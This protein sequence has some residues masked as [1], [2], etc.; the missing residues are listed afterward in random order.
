[1]KKFI[2]CMIWYFGN[3]IIWAIDDLI[4]VINGTYIGVLEGDAILQ[5]TVIIIVLFLPM[6]FFKN[7]KERWNWCGA[8]NIRNVLNA[9]Q[10]KENAGQEDY[11]RI[12]IVD[13][14]EESG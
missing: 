8:R 13:I 5:G 12:V 4:K 3:L 7:D 10:P 11:V 6:F 2:K 1:M 9:K 14:Q